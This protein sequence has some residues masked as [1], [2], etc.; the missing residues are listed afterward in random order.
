LER[1]K[2]IFE[3]FDESYKVS[4]FMYRTAYTE[5]MQQIPVAHTRT[6]LTIMV[7]K[8]E[9]INIQLA[10]LYKADPNQSNIVGYTD[11]ELV[12]YLLQRMSEHSK[13]LMTIRESVNKSKNDKDSWKTIKKNVA[14]DIKGTVRSLDSETSSN[15]DQALPPTSV[16]MA[17]E[18]VKRA[19]FNFIDYGKCSYGEGCRFS[20]EK[21]IIDKERNMGSRRNTGSSHHNSRKR[22][23]SVSPGSDS[24]RGNSRHNRGS[25]DYRQA[26]EKTQ[27]N[28]RNRSNSPAGNGNRFQGSPVRERSGSRQAGTPIRK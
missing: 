3:N 6:E 23:R 17:T 12:H 7:S 28:D 24:S 11:E 26:G 8:I 20:H 14:D 19:C 13:E 25:D 2:L 10:A 9:A 22:E 21:S 16:I 27:N 4:M 5:A 1:V 15:R 18:T